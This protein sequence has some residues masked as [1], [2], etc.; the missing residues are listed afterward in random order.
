MSLPDEQVRAVG[1]MRAALLRLCKPGRIG[2]RETRRLAFA[3]LKHC[4]SQHEL[5]EWAAAYL[6][7]QGRERELEWLRA[8]A[9]T[10]QEPWRER[11]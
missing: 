8:R 4:P 2:K 10:E 5:T 6:K 1:T 3:A 7:Q 9:I 11:R